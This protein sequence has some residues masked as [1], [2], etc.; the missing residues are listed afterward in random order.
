[1]TEINHTPGPWEALN[2]GTSND[3]FVTSIY[4][5]GYKGLLI[6]RCNQNANHFEDAKLIAAAPELYS[7]LKK[8]V[9]RLDANG[10]IGEYKGG[11]AF[12]MKFARAAL[13]KVERKS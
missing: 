1:M 11:P 2:E 6:A 10:G 12:V 4:S 13:E 9:E 7:S 3:N 8:L 5:E